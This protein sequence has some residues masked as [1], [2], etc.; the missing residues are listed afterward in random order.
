M[1]ALWHMLAMACVIV[2]LTAAG[3]G[4][5]LALSGRLT[6]ENREAIVKIL[7]GQPLN[8]PPAEVPPEPVYKTLNEEESLEMSERAVARTALLT[9]RQ[10]AELEYKEKQLENL[11]AQVLAQSQQLEG[12]RKALAAE[13]EQFAADLREGRAGDE[14]S[15][16]RELKLYE[17]MAPKQVRDIFMA[18][19]EKLAARFMAAMKP[20]M[21]ADVAASFKTEEEKQ[22]LQQLLG[23]MRDI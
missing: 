7:R 16:Q 11:R 18:L 20:A 4:V 6:P 15:F 17:Q 3:M 10:M 2:A 19:P 23:L 9:S 22:K 21:L 8:P 1:K 14:A 5:F 13:R 12:L